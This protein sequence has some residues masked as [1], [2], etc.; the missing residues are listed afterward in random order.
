MIIYKMS[1]RANKINIITP[2]SLK[3]LYPVKD[4][5]T[6]TKSR[7]EIENILL[8]NDNRI[9]LIVGPCSIH[10]TD[11]CITYAKKLVKLQKEYNSL[12]YIIMRCYLEKSRTSQ[13]WHGFLSSPNVDGEF[14]IEE[15]L[16]RGRQ[17]LVEIS[18]LG[19]PIAYEL[20]DPLVV[21]YFDDLI[22]WASVGARSVQSQLYRVLASSLPFP[23]GFKN[24]LDGEFLPCCN[25][26]ISSSNKN[27]FLSIDDSG[28][29]SI[30]NGKGNPASHLVLRGFRDGGKIYS[31]YDPYNLS[32]IRKALI[33]MHLDPIVVIDA[34]H[35]NSGKNPA[36]QEEAFF[37]VLKLK[38]EG[39]D[40]TPYGFEGRAFYVN[41]SSSSDISNM[42]R[43]V[44]LES[45]IE[46]GAI[47]EKEYR[48]KKQNG[49]SITDPCMS[50][51]QTERIIDYAYKKYK[52][53]VEDGEYEL[54]DEL[55]VLYKI[56][57]ILEKDK[58]LAPIK[59]IEIN[60][61]IDK[62]DKIKDGSN[63]QEKPA[64]EITNDIACRTSSIITI[65]KRKIEIYTDGACSGNPG[66]G[67]W[68]FVIVED[69]KIIM[70]KSGFE[71]ETTNN[72]MEMQAVI[73]ALHGIHDAEFSDCDL[74]LYTD[75]S[76]VKNGITQ[77]IKK[78]KQNGWISS[79]KT[80][81]KNQDLWL[82]L[83][84]LASSLSLNWRWV[85]GHAGNIF[86]ERCDRLATEQAQN[87]TGEKKENSDQRQLF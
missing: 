41:G 85:K 29:V 40:I 8:G 11:A 67:G 82:S 3:K 69:N 49:I 36:S 4:T 43:G 86:N 57:E 37:E 51:E 1:V 70:E 15:G 68:G 10:D 87:G 66:K 9:L 39:S 60:P 62:K 52:Y 42:I 48:Q 12:F 19:L 30:C 56:G 65:E 17:F 61:S 55:F 16:T 59:N 28:V 6:I 2:A 26:I 78:W 72:R 47:S 44:M 32:N 71:K 5:D 81:V 77:W 50:W 74:T 14:N 75:S 13:G 24:T 46:E 23:V 58:A 20:I 31:N 79:S 54:Y 38:Y 63:L 25:S 34:S 45:F 27:T 84:S 21:P 33:S 80:P 7:N 18:N 76:Y 22:S 73:Q 53:A 64:I 35:D 83:D